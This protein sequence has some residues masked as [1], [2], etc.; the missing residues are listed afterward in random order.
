MIRIYALLLFSIV[1]IPLFTFSQ[2]QYLF[3]ESDMQ[4]RL[5][6][7]ISV[8]ASDSF[9]GRE[10]GTDGEKL[11]SDYL[12]AALE[13]IGLSP[14]FGDTSYFQ[15]FTSSYF[16]HATVGNFMNINNENIPKGKSENNYYP[17]AYSGTGEL[18]GE[19]I[20]IGFGINSPSLSH[21]DYEEKTNISNRIFVI[22]TSIPGGYSENSAF[23]NYRYLRKKIDTAIAHNASGIIFINSDENYPN[24]TNELNLSV[25][26]RDIPILFYNGDKKNLFTQDKN[27]VDAFV[28]ITTFQ[29][30]TGK[31]VAGYINNNAEKT[32][33]IGGHYDHLGKIEQERK[34][35]Y[36]YNGAD[37]NA[38]GTA[39]VLEV[40]R[41][42]K[43][44]GYTNYNYVF[45]LFGAE[46]KG[47]LGS[48]H[49][50]SFNSTGIEQIAYMINL[51]MIGRSGV[52]SNDLIVY[53]VATSRS[54]RKMLKSS[55][56][57]FKK[58]KYF[59]GSNGGSDHHHFYNAR[60]PVLFFFTGLHKDYH[61]LTDHEE[62]INYPDAIKI[63]HFAENLI[64]KMENEKTP[65]FRKVSGI[66]NALTYISLF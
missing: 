55:N 36:I 43:Q 30:V 50:V 21:N 63:L 64:S 47:L 37:D 16:M 18:K 3:T 40:A 4:A 6:H 31:N 22:E 54:W 29:G 41:F 34:E 26:R 39:G 13:K 28:Q 59:G 7:D 17:I 53:G 19:L 33:V 15:S 27:S 51:D 14:Y 23:V 8:L 52:K 56:T 5:K 48:K 32:V 62:L 66:R 45:V 2:N 10:A 20:D 25:I 61:E 9:M 57:Y 44:S 65:Q 35:D 42:I 60:I 1:F 12:K 24:P 58:V 38:S 49:F 46:E 11:A